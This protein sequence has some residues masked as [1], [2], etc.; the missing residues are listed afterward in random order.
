MNE[1]TPQYSG[2]NSDQVSQPVELIPT[3]PQRKN[4]RPLLIIIAAVL[5]ILGIVALQM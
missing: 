5:A 4:T 1:N 2:Q 3:Q